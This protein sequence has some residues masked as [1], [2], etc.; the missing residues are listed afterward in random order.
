MAASARAPPVGTY[1]WAPGVCE[2]SE[3]VHPFLAHV[4]N[5]ISEFMSELYQNLKGRLHWKS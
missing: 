2:P 4:D 3:V 1:D 5:L